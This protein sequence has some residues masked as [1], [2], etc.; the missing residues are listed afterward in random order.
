MDITINQLKNILSA[1][2]LQSLINNSYPAEEIKKIKGWGDD[3]E[4]VIDRLLQFIIDENDKIL[5]TD[6]ETGEVLGEINLHSY[7]GEIIPA[8]SYE[9]IPE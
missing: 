3:N 6:P 2:T 4:A 1:D 5:L 8:G 7:G 9:A